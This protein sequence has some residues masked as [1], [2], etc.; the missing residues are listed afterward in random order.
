MRTLRVIFAVM[1]AVLLCGA[2]QRRPFA[3]HR[4]E[5]SLNL[6]VNTQ[7]ANYTP[8]ELPENMRVDLYDIRT[9]SLSYTDY[10]GPEGGVIRPAPGTYDML[11]HS[12]GSESTIVHNEHSFNEIEAYTNEV[13]SFIKSQLSQF[14]TKRTK[15]VME[16]MAKARAAALSAGVQTRDL[17]DYEEEPIVYQPDHIFVGRYDDLNVPAVHEDEM[18]E[19]IY[20]EV[21]MHT[22]VETWQVEIE[23]MEGAEWVGEVVAIVSGQRG[24]VHI[25]SDMASERMV[26]IFFDMSVEDREDGGK[27]LKGRFNTFGKHPEKDDGIYIDL[28]VRDKSGRDQMF[29]FEVTDRFMDNGD[30]I[31]FISETVVVEEPKAEGGGFQPIVGDWDEVRTEIA[32]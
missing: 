22:I 16:R 23:A 7:I 21:D 19:G 10:V 24:S 29:Q 8:E 5:L 17:S 15:A 12:L 31:I 20:A 27:C 1:S 32:L 13:S 14:L 25:G 11:V 3:E 18:F 28:N 9:G 6:E 4:T 30:R 26:S 2:C